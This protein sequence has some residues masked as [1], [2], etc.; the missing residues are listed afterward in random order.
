MTSNATDPPVRLRIVQAAAVW[1]APRLLLFFGYVLLSR[2][3]FILQTSDLRS[4]PW[5]PE[6]GL[7]VVAGALL[8]W[9]AIPIVFL[10]RTRGKPDLEPVRSQQ[11]AGPLG[12]GKRPDLHR[13]GVASS[14]LLQ[15]D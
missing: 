11:L 15:P 7:A 1:A 10:A 2:P 9:T 3:S 12:R 13:I 6:T 4:T 14:G 8:G 5:N